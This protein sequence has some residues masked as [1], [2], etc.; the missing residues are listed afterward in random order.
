DLDLVAVGHRGPVEPD[1]VGRVDQVPRPGG[2]GQGEPAA[3]VVVV[4][5]RLGD[6][7]DPDAVPAGAV[8]HPVDITLRVDDKCRPAVVHQVAA[9]AKGR[10]LDLQHFHHDRCPFPPGYPPPG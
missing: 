5:V 1:R 3:E 8:E 9:V 2:P 10:R 7:S 4:D 6:V